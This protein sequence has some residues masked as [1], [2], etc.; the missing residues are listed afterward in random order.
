M[1]KFD[2]VDNAYTPPVL[3]QFNDSNENSPFNLNKLL[4]ILPK[5][6][7][8][9]L[10]GGAKNSDNSFPSTPQN[11]PTFDTNQILHRQNTIETLKSINKHNDLVRRINDEANS[12]M[13]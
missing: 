6:N 9:L 1:K 11:Q 10:F 8:N 13:Q 5:L 4:Q 3:P 2:F 12:T 7:L